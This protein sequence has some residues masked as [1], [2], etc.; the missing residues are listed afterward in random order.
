MPT[1]E[2]VYFVG[3]PL[4]LSARTKSNSVSIFAL[5]HKLAYGIGKVRSHLPNC[6]Y[7][8]NIVRSADLPNILNNSFVVTRAANNNASA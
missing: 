4:R 1:L 8:I 7:Q 6:Q 3:C 2:A 5:T